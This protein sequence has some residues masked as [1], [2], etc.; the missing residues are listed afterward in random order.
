MFS[1]SLLT[2]HVRRF[3]ETNLKERG[4]F[5]ILLLRLKN[6]HAPQIYAT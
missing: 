4:R 5:G 3:P 2:E 6:T 1:A